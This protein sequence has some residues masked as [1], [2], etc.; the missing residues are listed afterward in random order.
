MPCRHTHQMPNMAA[1]FGLNI[2]G[3]M[4]PIERLLNDGEILKLGETAIRLIHTPGHTTG[5]SSFYCPDEGLVL[6]GDTLFQGSIG[7]TD[8]PGGNMEA[9]LDSINNK[10]FRLTIG[11]EKQHNYYM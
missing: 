7:R 6:C 1:Q 5:S 3:G 10:L 9:E 8:L 2:G 11:W 4:P